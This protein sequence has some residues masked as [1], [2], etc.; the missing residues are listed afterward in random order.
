MINFFGV[1]LEKIS[2]KQALMSLNKKQIIYTPNPEMLLVARSN[3]KF[4][5]VLNSGTM[6]LPD[7]HGL[8]FVSTL[9]K[10]SFFWRIILY[11][12]ALLL[13]AVYKKPFRKVFPEL[14]HGSDFMND[15]IFWAEKNKK[16][17]FLLGSSEKSA[18]G[19]S[20]FF[21]NKYPDLE[22]SYSSKNPDEIATKEIKDFDVIF[23]AYGAPKQEMWINENKNRIN[24]QII[25]GVG[26][27]FDFYSGTIKR[28]PILFRKLGLEWLW[29]LILQPRR[30]KRIFN[31]LI[32]FPIICVFSSPRSTSR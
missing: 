28:A 9:L 32:K 25:M 19:A 15:V 6:L 10:Y 13:F 8:L 4:A 12:P 5:D 23:V 22:I 27:S 21:K 31:A 3:K 16:S 17:V 29:R 2:K 7:G 18:R 24:A 26:G 11:I 20:L 14:I 1:K 30:I